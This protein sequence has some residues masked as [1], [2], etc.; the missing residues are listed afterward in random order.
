[1]DYHPGHLWR[2]PHEAGERTGHRG[3]A[4][5]KDSSWDRSDVCPCRRSL[6]LLGAAAVTSL[7]GAVTGLPALR[8]RDLYFGTPRSPHSS[9]LEYLIKTLDR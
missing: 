6:A 1:V 3:R 9:S 8:L 2:T 4:F 5:G 7:V